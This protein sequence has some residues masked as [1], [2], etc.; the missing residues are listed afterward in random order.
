MTVFVHER[1]D[2]PAW[3]AMAIGR[4]AVHW[5]KLEWELEETIRVLLDVDIQFAR[6][7]TTDM[8]VSRRMTTAVNLLQAHMLNNLL[9]HA[10]H[11]AL[12]K[13]GQRIEQAEGHRN[14]LIHGHWGLIEGKW[15][16]MRRRTGRVV[17]G[18]GQR[19]PLKPVKLQR[20]VLPQLELITKEKVSDIYREV[21]S[22]AEAIAVLRSTIQ[23]LLPP[24]SR[25][26]PKDIKQTVPVHRRRVKRP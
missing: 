13:L 14:K 25:L 8:N 7:V 12:I 10:E 11:D 6:I 22:C 9:S 4:T 21:A 3:L 17:P 15:H 16:L 24:S 1:T 23:K 26:A 19:P 20:A 2:V 5:S 18:F